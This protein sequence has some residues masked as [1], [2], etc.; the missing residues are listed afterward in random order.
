MT[1]AELEIIVTARLDEL[2]AKLSEAKGIAKKGGSEAGRELAQSLA[3]GFGQ[4][5]GNFSVQGAIDGVKSLLKGMVSG[6]SEMEGYTTQFKVLLGTVTEAK[7]RMAELAKFAA[8][9]PFE[10]P[11]VVS[12]S[13]QL[14][15][16]GGTALA[17]GQTLKMVGDMASAS[18]A[19][20]QEVAT[21][22]GRLYSNLQAGKPFGEATQRLQELGLISGQTRN[23]MEDLAKKGGKAA[24]V[25]DIFTKASQRFNGMMDEQSKTLEGL[26]STLK[27]DFA[28][29]LREVGAPVFDKVKEGVKGLIGVFEKPEFKGAAKTLAA[30]V[31]GVVGV[32]GAVAG[33]AAGIMAW[34]KVAAAFEMVSG[35]V[36]GLSGVLTALSGPVGWVIAAAALIYAAWKTNFLGI[37]D[38]VGK[39]VQEIVG[40]WQ[41]NLPLIQRTTATVLTWVKN[42]WATLAPHLKRVW[43]VIVSVVNIAWQVISGIVQT[44]L[45]LVGGI[46]S[47]VMLAI[48]GRWADAWTMLKLTCVRVFATIA[49]TTV[50]T[51]AAVLNYVD[52]FA[53]TVAGVFGQ[54]FT[55]LDGAQKGLEGYAKGWDMVGDAAGNA[56]GAISKSVKGF[57]NLN[58]IKGKLGG[59]SIDVGFPKDPNP[60][61]G[62]EGINMGG[63]DKGGKSS[64]PKETQ[65][66]KDLNAQI[67]E[68]QTMIQGL[69][70]D[71]RLKGDATASATLQ[72]KLSHGEV[73]KGAAAYAQKALGLTRDKEAMDKSLESQ[74][75]LKDSL[76]DLQKQLRATTLTDPKDALAF[77][78][79]GK[80]F[81]QL[82]DP[83]NRA[84][85]E[86]TVKAKA[87]LLA[88]EAT[89]TAVQNAKSLNAQLM[90]EIDLWGQTTRVKQASLELSKEEYKN[91][92]AW[93][94][95][96]I[97]AHATYLDQLKNEADL[98]EKAQKSWDDSMEAMEKT[99][100][101]LDDQASKPLKAWKD[102]MAEL[103]K[104]LEEFKPKAEGMAD[105]MARLTKKYGGGDTGAQRAKDFLDAQKNLDDQR[106]KFE[107]I[108]KLKDSLQEGFMDMFDRLWK[109][110]F[111]NFFGN[112]VGGFRSMVAQI[113]Q[114]WIKSQV[115]GLVSRG[116]TAIFSGTGGAKGLLGRAVGGPVNGGQPY[117][118]GENGPELF[119]P[120]GGGSIRTNAATKGM[121]GTTI[122]L[123]VSGVR[124]A[125]SFLQ[126]ESQINAML[127]RAGS[128]AAQ[129]TG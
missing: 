38:F 62:L 127:W 73:L 70:R 56:Q 84:A 45:R 50:R 89:Q 44:A 18:G 51:L 31:A 48:N 108:A 43:D 71:L 109:D 11:E 81:A 2:N 118:V 29:T 49:A 105:A 15:V 97:M 27:D 74:R 111:S 96:A 80:T 8:V 57:P 5:I 102:D 116:L 41:D 28:A 123:H 59:K 90:Q 114:E 69:R 19:G 13:K 79:F 115:A 26:V 77:Q 128:A 94:K 33:L 113:A 129:A 87:D 85:I 103:A 17:T 95:Q 83:K 40:W 55:G 37:R 112:V 9:T 121:G 119:V 61:A 20:Y 1:V 106:V 21:W 36:G 66:Q 22:V 126:S 52:K 34:G 58:P 42:A 98:H 23:Q 110:G 3:S 107:Q 67:K 30:I 86:A 92:P 120:N 47:T 78:E 104:R 93:L 53:D 14:Q 4:A 60:R 100:A 12:A 25:W 76:A 16:M 117:V 63:G 72:D 64:K 54:Q 68:Y 88:S 39:V 125:G 46:I 24:D 101:W 124:D 32:V 91:V 10:L 7:G 122:N 6:N 35:A 75:R 82:T 99:F 65:E